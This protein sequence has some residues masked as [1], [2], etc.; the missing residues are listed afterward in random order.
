MDEED[1]D[2]YAPNGDGHGEANVKAED[3]NADTSM[4]DQYSNARHPQENDG[5]EEER[6]DDEGDDDDDDDEEDDDDSDIDIITERQDG[7]APE[8]PQARAFRAPKPDLPRTASVDTSAPATKSH[9]PTTTSKADPSPAP[10]SNRVAVSLKDGST[11][12]AIHSSNIQIDS[13]PIWTPAGKLITEV[14][15][16]ADLAGHTK[17]WR[18]PGTDQTD[19]FNYG[20]DEFTWTQYCLR[21]QNMTSAI[22][23]QKQETKQFEMMLANQPG[24]AAAAPQGQPAMPMGMPGMPDMPPDMMNAMF[25]SMSAQGV[26]DPSQLDFAS[27]M[28]QMQSMGG[29]PGMPGMPNMPGQSG[30]TASGGQGAFG[31]Q[32]MQQQNSNQGYP[33]QQHVQSTYSHQQQGNQSYS[34]GTPQPQ[35]QGQQGGGN[36]FEG[37][38][39]QQLA[40]MPGQGAGGPPQG[41]SGGGRGRARGRRW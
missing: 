1:D 32:V 2:F 24:A 6:G 25:A 38:S 34:G 28:H 17:P 4:R 29:M 3:A 30:P 12:P 10:Q 13:N 18:L 16:D 39:A 23:A 36:G 37:Y 15:I 33:S 7:A 9:Q 40:M 20:F 27:F 14:D 31:G 21:Q 41:P 19:Y 26:N 5:D 11:Y 35:G 8:P 22:N